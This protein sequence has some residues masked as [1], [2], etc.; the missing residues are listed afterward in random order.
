MKTEEMIKYLSG[1]STMQDVMISGGLAGKIADRLRELQLGVAE[2]K[3][4]LDNNNP[5]KPPVA[6]MVDG[7]IERA[8]TFD[9]AEAENIAAMNCGNVVPLYTQSSTKGFSPATNPVA[10]DQMHKDFEQWSDDACY[11]GR[12]LTRQL[13]IKTSAG[14]AYLGAHDMAWKA[15][16]AATIKQVAHGNTKLTSLAASTPLTTKTCAVHE[17]CKS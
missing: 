9:K 2:L 4:Q 7:R 15:W 11:E 3:Y 14:N 17:G 13:L 10:I 5:T 1:T 16:K 6:H 8:L 12:K